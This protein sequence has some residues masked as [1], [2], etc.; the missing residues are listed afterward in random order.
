LPTEIVVREII[1][2]FGLF[3]LFLGEQ[4]VLVTALIVTLWLLYFTEAR[5]AGPAL[6]PQ[7]AITLTNTE[8]GVFLDI[9][10]AKDFK[11]GHIAGAINI[12]S[13]SLPNRMGELNAYQEKPVI[14]VCRLGQTSSAAVKQLRAEGFNEAHRMAG[15]MLSWDDNRLPVTK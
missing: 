9:R 15:G 3:L 7:Q 13:A 5:K 6:S 11:Q 4:W 8:G 2:S 14:V 12:P 10:E 1:V